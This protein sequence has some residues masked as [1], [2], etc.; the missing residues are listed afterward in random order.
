MQPGR[1]GF[2]IIPAFHRSGFQVIPAF[3]RSGFS[4]VVPVTVIKIN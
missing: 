3:R 2:P 1:S 4:L